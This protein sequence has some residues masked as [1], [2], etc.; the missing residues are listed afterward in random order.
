[1]LWKRLSLGLLLIVLGG[2]AACKEAAVS[3]P[4]GERVFRTR[5]ASCHGREGEKVLSPDRPALQ[6]SR[7][8]VERIKNAVREGVPPR[9]PKTPM[10]EDTLQF[11]A[12]YVHQL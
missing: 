5:C 3:N 1:M 2:L 11:L 9:M 12:E 10:E 7:L 4:V 8:P 6:G